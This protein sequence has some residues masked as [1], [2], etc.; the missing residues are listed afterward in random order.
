MSQA[1]TEAAGPYLTKNADLQTPP[2]L[3]NASVI[4]AANAAVSNYPLKPKYL[5]E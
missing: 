1:N 3:M 5:Q 2:G 4:T